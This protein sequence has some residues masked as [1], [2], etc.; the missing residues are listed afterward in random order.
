MNRRSFDLNERYLFA[1]LYRPPDEQM[2]TRGLI[3][4]LTNP[5]I[6]KLILS[7]PGHGSYEQLIKDIFGAMSAGLVDVCCKGLDFSVGIGSCRFRKSRFRR[8][9]N[10]KRCGQGLDT[11]L[12]W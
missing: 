11:S 4:I 10:W 12:V 7:I 5:L 3:Y 6:P 1:S 2:H 8:H 9:H